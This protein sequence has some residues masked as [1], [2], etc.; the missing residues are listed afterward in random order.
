M[1]ARRFDEMQKAWN[2]QYQLQIETGSVAQTTR[3]VAEG[4][5]ADLL[6]IGRGHEHGTLGRLP[7]NTYAIIRESPCPVIAV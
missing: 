5:H 2:T 7:T 6:V 1:T 3:E 4:T